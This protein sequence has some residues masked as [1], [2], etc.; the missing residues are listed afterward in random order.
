[1]GGEIPIETVPYPGFKRLWNE[2]EKDENGNVGVY[3]LISHLSRA[4]PVVDIFDA[5]Q[6][7]VVCFRDALNDKKN[8]LSDNIQEYSSENWDDAAPLM[9]MDQEDLRNLWRTC[10]MQEGSSAEEAR[11]HMFFHLLPQYTHSDDVILPV[12]KKHLL[13]EYHAWNEAQLTEKRQK[14]YVMAAQVAQ[15]SSATN[16]NNPHDTLAGVE[17][18]RT[19]VFD[20]SQRL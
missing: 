15:D 11:C 12:N 9:Q 1:M 4:D 10:S 18:L 6:L 3:E 16:G 14:Q 13:N 17:Q 20:T 2:L 5:S 7:N 19:Q 8:E